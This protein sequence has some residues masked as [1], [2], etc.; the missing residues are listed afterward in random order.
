[1]KRIDG[2]APRR[3]HAGSSRRPRIGLS[4]VPGSVGPRSLRPGRRDPVAKAFAVAALIE[5]FVDF[6]EDESGVDAPVLLA[7]DPLFRER[8]RRRLWRSMG[9]TRMYDGRDIH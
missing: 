4:I 2:D 5:D 8:L 1:M 9:F 6:L 3:A 7:P